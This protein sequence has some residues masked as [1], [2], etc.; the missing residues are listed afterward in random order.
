[1][2]DELVGCK[3][4]RFEIA[5]TQDQCLPPARSGHTMTF[6]KKE[7]AV[8]LYGGLGEKYF[9]DVHVYNITALTWQ[10]MQTTGVAP[11]GTFGHV[12]VLLG[13]ERTIVV[14]G[15]Q[16]NDN[17]DCARNLY[18]LDIKERSWNCIPA[19]LWKERWGQSGVLLA[20]E[21]SKSPRGDI[22][23]FG[24]MAGEK[25]KNDLTRLDTKKWTLTE[26]PTSQRPPGRRRHTADTYRDQY[27]FVFGGRSEVQ[28][29]DDLWVYSLN[30][31]MWMEITHHVPLYHMRAIWEC[32]P[33]EQSKLFCTQFR[34]VDALPFCT[35]SPRTGH[36]SW[37]IN[38]CLY[39]FA[40]FSLNQGQVKLLNDVHCYDILNHEWFPV[41]CADE[42][43]ET[44]E[45]RSMGALSVISTT[46]NCAKLLLHGGREETDALGDSC[47]LSVV[48]RCNSMLYCCLQKAVMMDLDAS[49]LSCLPARVREAFH[50]MELMPLDGISV[51]SHFGPNQG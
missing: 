12:A 44:Y 38:D 18:A 30:C 28:W 29:F 45:P 16:C 48:P 27:M 13:D 43:A 24:G 39:I 41:V 5:S 33:C 47:I 40:G 6:V 9:N 32:R 17:G 36:C 51:V 46:D 7:N 35:A 11:P 25:G 4:A 10:P 1:M 37:L 26:I 23:L 19:P 21:H 20:K 22:L 42:S 14:L 3:P 15:G 8:V 34:N 49:S 2:F 31:Q 50:L